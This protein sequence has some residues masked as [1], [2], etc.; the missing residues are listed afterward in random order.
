MGKTK[1]N[2]DNKP[3]TKSSSPQEINT[4]SAALKRLVSRLRKDVRQMES[5]SEDLARRIERAGRTADLFS[6]Q[7]A[8]MDKE[9][10]SDTNSKK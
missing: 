3:I 5:A 1:K 4:S 10:K 6:A 2:V 9:E 8:Q 7:L